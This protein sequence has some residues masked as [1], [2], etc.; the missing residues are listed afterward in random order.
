[1]R[2]AERRKENLAAASRSSPRARPAVMVEPERETPGMTAP[3]W[4]RPMRRASLS[5]ADGPLVP[6][7]GV[8]EPEEGAEEGH[9]RGHGYH[10]A[11]GDRVLVEGRIDPAL[12]E[13][14]RDAAG[15]AGREE[16]PGHAPVLILADL[17][18]GD[19]L[20]PRL[21]ELPPVRGEEDD[22]GEEASEVEGHVEAQGA[23]RGVVPAEEPG[24]DDEVGRARDGDEFRKALDD[25][26]EDGLQR[27]H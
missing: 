6:G 10:R 3:A 2:G 1:M 26:E 20:E 5:V 15:H 16:V 4:A 24:K 18:L 21:D 14:A 12:E 11:A 9:G 7:L 19:A 27:K 23:D 13:D 25:A 17:A 8:G 22:D